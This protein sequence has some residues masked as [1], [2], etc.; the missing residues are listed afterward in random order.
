[1]TPLLTTLESF[2]DRHRVRKGKVL[3]GVSGGA[4]SVALLLGLRHFATERH[5][6]LVVGH[7][8]HAMRNDSAADAQW[9]KHLCHELGLE[10]RI[11]RRQIAG[12]EETS[13][14]GG[15][16]VSEESAR[17][18]RYE[19][20]KTVASEEKCSWVAVA[21]TAD[22]QVETVLHHILRGSG[23]NG[24]RGIPEVRS[25]KGVP[26]V[27]ELMLIRPFLNVSRN[28]IDSFL[29]SL[30]QSFRED[31]TNASFDY[32][33][34]RLR[35]VVLP[36]LRTEFNPR[37][38]QALLQLSQQAMDAQIVINELVGKLFCDAVLDQQPGHVRLQ[39]SLLI[40]HPS[41]IL[42]AFFAHLWDIQEWPRQNLGFAHLDQ[43]ARMVVTQTPS[44]HSLPT[45]ITALCREHFFELRQPI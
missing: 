10:A 13:A 1:M 40:A 45:G 8:D 14:I 37:I 9:V 21:H 7:F 6:Q 20:L 17:R 25:L 4:D 29:E 11:A 23:L 2:L 35:H 15:K 42:R 5:L 24:L 3:I 28:G 18:D 16:S 44:R 27:G 32:T 31:P 19:F 33:R 41:G 38:D 12:I 36:M 34:N 26:S 30:S 43:L 39:R 22:D